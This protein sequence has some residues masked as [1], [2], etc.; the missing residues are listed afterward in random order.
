MNRKQ[1]SDNTMFRAI[2]FFVSNRQKVQLNADLL[3]P[4]TQVF[5]HNANVQLKLNEIK[6]IKVWLKREIKLELS[7]NLQT[8]GEKL[9]PWFFTSFTK[10]ERSLCLL[11]SYWKYVLSYWILDQRSIVCR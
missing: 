5:L 3:K 11:K 4:R 2:E 6:A 8:V 1:L 9:E 7:F 10:N